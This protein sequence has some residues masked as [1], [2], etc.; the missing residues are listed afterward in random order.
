MSVDNVRHEL[1]LLSEGDDSARANAFQSEVLRKLSGVKAS[2]QCLAFAARAKNRYPFGWKTLYNADQ[3]TFQ[4]HE[5]HVDEPNGPAGVCC[6]LW[7]PACLR[8]P[9]LPPRAAG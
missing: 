9:A 8:D 7:Y 6:G 4:H 5:R 3:L 1:N 2:R